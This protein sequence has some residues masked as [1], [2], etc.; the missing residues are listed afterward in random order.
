ML[1]NTWQR[2]LSCLYHAFCN[3][4]FSLI[5]VLHNGFAHFLFENVGNIFLGEMQVITDSG[6]GDLSG[7]IFINELLDVD[8][9][10]MVTSKG[11]GIYDL[12]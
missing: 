12:K 1:G 10:G 2:Q 5:C 11:G 8:Y 9:M 4:H 7:K 3:Q 6:Q